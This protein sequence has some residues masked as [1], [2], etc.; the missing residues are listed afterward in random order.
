MYF[1]PG[2]ECAEVELAAAEK[3]WGIT[4][5]QYPHWVV[6]KALTRR[7]LLQPLLQVGS[8]RL[9]SAGRV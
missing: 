8:P 3:R 9:D 1:V 4:I 7:R 5:H 6:G 2:L